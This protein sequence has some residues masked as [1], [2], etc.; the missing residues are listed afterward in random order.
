MSKEWRQSSKLLELGSFDVC[1]NIAAPM[2]VMLDCLELDTEISNAGIKTSESND[3]KEIS[4]ND[5]DVNGVL[6]TI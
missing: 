6:A 4:K 5:G 3:C 1:K 2:I